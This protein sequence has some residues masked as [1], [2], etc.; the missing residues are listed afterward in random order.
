MAAQRHVSSLIING[1]RFGGVPQFLGWAFFGM[2]MLFVWAFSTQ[3]DVG[4]VVYALSS[5]ERVDGHVTERWVTSTSVNDE[6]IYG[7]SF[8]FTGPDDA[9]H[10]SRSYGTYS[11]VPDKGEYVTIE[12]PSLSPSF[13]RVQGT[14][15]GRV[16]MVFAL[17]VALFPGIGLTLL[18]FTVPRAWRAASLLSNGLL[19]QALLLDKEA[20]NTKINKQTVYRM[21]LEFTDQNGTAH[22][23]VSKTHEPWKLEDDAMEWVLYD[24]AEPSRATTV[25]DLPGNLAVTDH[26][27]V[28]GSGAF[29]GILVALVSIV[30]NIL[31]CAGF[32]WSVSA[33]FA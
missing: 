15:S 8:A 2:G 17:V 24:P 31:G 5:V 11:E 27:Q 13:A 30:A 3:A 20:T 7:V 33:W 14:R 19:T 9:P 26:G 28:E 4:P 16:P 1:V 22:T 6:Q 23:V 29:G 25:D 10:T 18:F 32:L 21:T 12:V